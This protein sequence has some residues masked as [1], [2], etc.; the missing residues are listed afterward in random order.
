MN[1]EQAYKI[2]KSVGGID[3]CDEYDC[4]RL[5]L[6]YEELLA[7]A[8]AVLQ[9]QQ[10]EVPPGYALAMAV[11]QSSLYQF[12]DDVERAECDALIAAAQGAKPE[13]EIPASEKN[14]RPQNCGTGY[15]S[16]IECP[17]PKTDWS[18]A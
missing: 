7:F 16:C 13:T 11:L 3:Y 5:E 4:R 10:V 15:C 12:L 9:E 8:H 6:H 1:Q 18:A 2:F 17:Y 14:E